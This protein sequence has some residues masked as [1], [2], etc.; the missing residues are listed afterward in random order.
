M[1]AI[2]II[3]IIRLLLTNYNYC[4]TIFDYITDK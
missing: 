4:Y 3:I 1:P 2:T